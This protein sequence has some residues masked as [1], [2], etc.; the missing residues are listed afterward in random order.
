MRVY[1][2]NRVE[3]LLAALQTVVQTPRGGPFD[4]E[5]IVVHSRAMSVWLSMRLAEHFGAWAGGAFP[6]PRRF[7]HDAITAALGPEA[8]GTDPWRADR[9]VWSILAELPRHL[10]DPAFA[11]LKR[12]LDRDPREHGRFELARRIADTFDQ[13]AVFRSELVLD[14]QSGRGDD[15]QPR[16]WRAL[17][18]RIGGR[19]PATLAREFFGALRAGRL[20]R[21]R[22]PARVSVF[23]ISALPPMYVRML[24]AL[25]EHIEVHLLVLSPSQE[26]WAEIRSQRE[27]LRAAKN[28]PESVDLFAGDDEGNPLLAS[29]GA[30]GRDFQRILEAE[31][32]YEEPG[33]SLYLDPTGDTMLAHLQADVLHLRRRRLADATAMSIGPRPVD[34]I[35]IRADDDSIRLHA[36]HSP[37]REV[38]VLHDQLMELLHEKGVAPDEILVLTPDMERY[39]PLIEAVFERG[40]TSDARFIPFTIADRAPRRESPVLEALLRVF[41]MVGGRATASSVLDLLALDVVQ[42]RFDIDEDDHDTVSEWVVDSGI[43]WGMDARHRQAHDQPR[44]A[45]NTWEFGLRRM[46]LGYAMPGDGRTTFAG[47]LPFDEVEGTDAIVLGKLADLVHTLFAEVEDLQAPRTLP[48][49]RDRIGRTLDALCVADADSAWEHQQIRVALDATVDDATAAG[50]DDAVEIR[51]LAERLQYH[52][53]QD[54]PARGL[55]AGGVTFCALLPM[56]TLPFSVVGLLGMND[57]DFPRAPTGVGFDLI[58]A[59]PRPGDRSRRT[60]DRYLFLEALLSARTRL[61]ATYVGQSIN[62]NSP[63]PPSVALAELLDVMSQGFLAPG[64][65][66]QDPAAVRTAALRDF[67]VLRHPMQPFSPRY[68]GADD[69]PRLFSYASAWQDGARA[70]SERRPEEGAPVLLR[71]PLPA[72]SGPREVSIDELVRRLT[73]PCAELLKRRLGINLTDYGREH[74]DREP[75]ELDGLDQWKVGDALLSLRM[76]AVSVDRCRE[77]MFARGQLPL[78]ALG[79]ARFDAIVAEVDT[80]AAS[81]QALRGSERVPDVSIDLFIGDTRLVGRIGDRWSGA[82]VVPKYARVGPKHQLHAWIRHLVLGVVLPQEEVVTAI[83]GKADRAGG[84]ALC[85]LRPVEA[86]LPLVESLVE[87]YW[88]A[89]REPVLLFPRSSC[90]YAEALPNGP[91]EALAAARKAWTERQNPEGN[92]PHLRRLFGDADPL[93]PGF[94]PFDA[95][96]SAGDFATVATR[97][98]CPLLE[99]RREH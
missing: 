94:T 30:V 69:D 19:H 6:F 50:F 10:A 22:L 26:Y 77:L 4:P 1:R 59:H 25:A 68:F 37:M 13:Y 78:G 92:D 3:Q 79:E 23:G 14:W 12:Y 43:R 88:I 74:S 5:T 45:H 57:G 91:A 83:V 28:A 65:S 87:L 85:E 63:L 17:V 36:C 38:E 58:A 8:A 73:H 70:V 46:L 64:I 49:W 62:D 24:A 54:R 15:W 9:L 86:P 44:D 20:D 34:P 75:T 90:A 7:M 2:S 27:A 98:F 67:V 84:A 61:I 31:V 35:A 93:A 29:Y 32:E 42:R 81:A 95:P 76:D 40:H 96:L 18:E 11:P 33:P 60:D 52:V 82:V 72:P 47:V 56:R 66:L 89:L 48:Q 51:T 99:H 16:L 97:V 21:S 55:L 53:E 39:G 80:I 71:G 41:A